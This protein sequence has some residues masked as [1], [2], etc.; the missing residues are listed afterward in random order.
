[1]FKLRRQTG[2]HRPSVKS[3]E[4]NQQQTAPPN[5][6]QFLATFEPAASSDCRDG[7]DSGIYTMCSDDEFAVLRDQQ[8]PEAEKAAAATRPRRIPKVIAVVREPDGQSRFF[9]PELSRR[10]GRPVWAPLQPIEG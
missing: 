10:A 2:P 3:R 8:P 5:R 6:Y 9:N 7:Q 4:L 1:M